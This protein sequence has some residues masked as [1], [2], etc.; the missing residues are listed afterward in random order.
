NKTM[1]YGDA[2][3]TLTASIS[4]NQNGDTNTQV[5]SGGAT[6]SITASG[7]STSGNYIF[8]S[9]TIGT[10]GATSSL[11]YNI[12][13]TTGT[14]SVSQRTVTVS[15]ITASNKVYDANRTATVSISGV[16][17]ANRINGDLITISSTGLFDTKNAADGKTVTLTST[18]GGTDVNN[19]SFTSQPTTTANITQKALDIS[20]LTAA[21]KTYDGN[22]TASLSGTAVLTGSSTD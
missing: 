20:G 8:G 12:S 14:L 22:T 19:Y 7:T 5:L 9:H 10:S 16:I 2:T 6:L 18:Y 3:P 11:G 4:G 21:N 1:V 17:F 13:Y 15:G